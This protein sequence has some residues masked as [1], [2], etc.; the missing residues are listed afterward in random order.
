ME[1]R[2][3]KIYAGA[4]WTPVIATDL[5]NG[6]GGNEWDWVEYALR[7]APRGFTPAQGQLLDQRVA[8]Y[9]AASDFTMLAHARRADFAAAALILPVPDSVDLVDR[10][11]IP[12]DV[13]RGGH[14]P[15]RVGGAAAVAWHA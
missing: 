11:G 5:F 1:R 12:Y 9:P 10:A 13:I 2:P 6:S 15:H 14:L 8:A 3:P 4:S 7:Q